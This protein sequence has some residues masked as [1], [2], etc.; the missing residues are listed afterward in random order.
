M[1][2]LVL[3]RPLEVVPERE[4]RLEANHIAH[5]FVR[6]GKVSV[7]TIKYVRRNAFNKGDPDD[8]SWKLVALT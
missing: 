6:I 4:F 7:V 3:Q 8:F 2:R 5:E 1:V